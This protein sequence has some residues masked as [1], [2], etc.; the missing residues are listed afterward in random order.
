M[1]LAEVIDG[2]PEPVKG[3]VA[4]GLCTWAAIAFFILYVLRD[5]Y[6]RVC[7]RR[8]AFRERAVDDQGY[9]L[10]HHHRHCSRNDGDD[11]S[12]DNPHI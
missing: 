12:T 11:D 8:L 7:Q 10:C 3:A 4:T 2:I 5:R 6:C 1:N 9:D